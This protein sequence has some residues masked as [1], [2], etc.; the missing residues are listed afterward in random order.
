VNDFASAYNKGDA[1]KLYGLIDSQ[2]KSACNQEDFSAAVNEA[3]SMTAD[4]QLKVSSVDQIVVNGDQ[5]TALI[6]TTFADETGEPAAEEFLKE[7][8]K[9]KL[10][11]SFC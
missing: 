11:G 9:W 3:R 4:A 1:N 2:S 6:V 10:V 5:A 8:G 7:G